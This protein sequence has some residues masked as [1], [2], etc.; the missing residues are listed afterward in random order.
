VTAVRHV[1]AVAQL[2][3]ER[4]EGEPRRLARRLADPGIAVALGA[5]ALIEEARTLHLASLDADAGLAALCIPW[6]EIL[7]ETV[8]LLGR[9][10]VCCVR[11]GARRPRRRRVCSRCQLP[12]P[13]SPF[14]VFESE[15]RS[16]AWIER[17]TDRRST[18]GGCD[19]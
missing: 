2:V 16:R 5:Q 18:A 9:T 17:R 13:F 10:G 1:R 4:I 7:A 19:E 14:S 8:E 12:A 15:V 6:E 3:A 11:C